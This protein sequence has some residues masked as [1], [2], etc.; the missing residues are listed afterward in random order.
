MLFAKEKLRIRAP[1]EL[2]QYL[3]KPVELAPSLH[4]WN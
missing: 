1:V 4:E 3:T 2:G